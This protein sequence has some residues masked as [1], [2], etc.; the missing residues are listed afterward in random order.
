MV[1]QKEMRNESRDEAFYLL[2]SNKCV[3]E[4]GEATGRQE[5]KLFP[6]AVITRV[7]QKL[8]VLWTHLFHYDLKTTIQPF[9]LEKNLQDH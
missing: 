4:V 1:K 7:L 2:G 3:E 8:T 9:R 6:A 5:N